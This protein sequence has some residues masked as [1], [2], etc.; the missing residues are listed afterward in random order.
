MLRK[1]TNL[2]RADSDAGELVRGSSVYAILRAIGLAASYG[3]HLAVA[4]L[5]GARSAG[6]LGLA[7]TMLHVCAMFASLGT[8]QA[9]VRFVAEYAAT[10]QKAVRAVRRSVL[11]VTVPSSIL[12]ACLLFFSAP[13]IA[14]R[15]FHDPPVST[16]FRIMSLMLPIGAMMMAN[17]ASLRGLRLIPQSA[18][19][20]S[21]V[22]PV[23]RVGALLLV[24]LVSH[25]VAV[26]V[27]AHC[28]GLTAAAVVS[29]YFWVRAIRN[30]PAGSLAQ[31]PPS[32][33]ILV[34]AWPMLIT[35]FYQYIMG[36][37]DTIMLGMLTDTA[38]VGIYRTAL[39]VSGLTGI[40]LI[41]V[42]SIAGPKFAAIRA[43]ADHSRLI[44]VVKRR[45]RRCLLA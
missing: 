44:H 33:E 18:G 26:P 42:G 29:Y 39:K 32:R 1:L 15:L 23:T 16:A 6:V 17:I 2:L 30:L 7:L 38:E 35:T 24:A 11:N 27:V 20:D 36:W 9:L 25:R 37:T 5:Y 41:A 10:G 14:A 45:Y 19:C 13:W 43:E 21:F 28:C 12:A 3:F 8:R 4:R 34:V 31:A 22:L 40:S